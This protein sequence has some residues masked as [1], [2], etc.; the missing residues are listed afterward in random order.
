MAEEKKEATIEVKMTDA[1]EKKA[2]PVAA[3][4]ELVRRMLCFL[5]RRMANRL[6]FSR[7][8]RALDNCS[9]RKFSRRR[10][11]P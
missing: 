2:E 3:G 10:T 4:D 6:L 9:V 8:L 1:E 11:A 7:A 5:V